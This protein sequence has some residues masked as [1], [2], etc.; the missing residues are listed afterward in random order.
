[1]VI[2]KGD[3]CYAAPI[4]AILARHPAVAEAAIVGRESPLTGEEIHAFLVPA[5]GQARTGKTATE[6][7]QLVVDELAPA[8]RPV[9]V[10]WI[11]KMPLVASG[12]PDKKRLRA[13]IL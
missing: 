4:E 5:A 8:H 2:V 13:S 7:C 9:A 12:K 3:N 1:M 10:H 6:A 11:D